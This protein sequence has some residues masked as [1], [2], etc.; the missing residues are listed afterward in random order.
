MNETNTAQ[1]L[2]TKQVMDLLQISRSTVHRWIEQGMPHVKAGAHNRFSRAEI[3]AWLENGQEKNDT[4]DNSK[5][6]EEEEIIIQPGD[7]RCQ[8]CG[9]GGH[10][11]APRPLSKIWC[12]RCHAVGQIAP[13]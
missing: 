12:P 1:Y 8:G 10:I 11:Q 2:T 3:L 9:W 7:Y 5:H 13:A 4:Q 6:T